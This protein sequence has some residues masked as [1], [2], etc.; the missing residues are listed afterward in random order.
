MNKH[1]LSEHLVFLVHVPNCRNKGYPQPKGRLLR[2]VCRRQKL[3]RWHFQSL[4]I[5]MGVCSN[6][7]YEMVGLI[8]KSFDLAKYFCGV[9]GGDNVAFNKPDDRHIRVTLKRMNV[10]SDNVLMVGD[11]INDVTAA[12]DAGLS[13][14]ALDY[15]Y[16]SPDELLSATVII[17]EFGK[18]K[19]AVT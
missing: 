15:G 19:S 1:C 11:T 10:S 16:S 2:P 3:L 13:V 9:T 14:V 6:K 18:L 4:G 8:L 7:A 12:Q 17:D 5:K